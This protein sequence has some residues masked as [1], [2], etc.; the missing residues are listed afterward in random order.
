M[1]TKAQKKA[2]EQ[3][4]LRLNKGYGHGTGALGSDPVKLDVWPTGIL[5]LDYALGTGGYGKG[6]IVEVFGPEDIGKSSAIGLSAIR[7]AQKEGALCGVIAVEP[8]WD[9]GWVSKNGVDLESVIIARPDD[10]EDAFNILY[11]WVMSDVI[12][13]ILFDSIG[14]LL[15]GT[16]IDTGKP[17]KKAKPSQAGQS[18]LI[19][20]G[21]KRVVMPA[22]KRR[23]TILFMNQVRDKMDSMYSMLDSPGGH[24]LKHS[25]SQ[26][27]QLKPKKVHTQTVDEDKGVVVGRELVAEIVRN[28]L[29]EG[30]KQRAVFDYW[31]MDTDDNRV[32]ID[33]ADDLIRVGKKTGVISGTG[34]LYHELFP[35]DKKGEHKLQGKA[36]V[37]E[38]LVE[39]P[40][41]YDKIRKQILEV[42]IERAEQPPN[43]DWVPETE[44]GDDDGD[45]AGS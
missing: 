29:S 45:V 27:I 2:L 3:E 4:K 23:K 35:E 8:N 34:W 28:K 37:R 36:K 14:A 20:W 11:D 41:S 1:A 9:T 24:A 22:F 10:G 15:K 33:L 7:A 38:W 19:T 17:D 43:L 21:V 40:K 13:V 25:V 31:Q 42:M 12:D 16:E 39:N 30:T 5:A 18:P 26:R 32:G 44:E 6:Y